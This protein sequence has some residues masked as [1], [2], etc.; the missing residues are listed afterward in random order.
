MRRAADNST[1]PKGGVSCSKD[2][3]MVNQT[4]IFQIKYCGKS[5][6]LRVAAKRY[7]QFSMTSKKAFIIFILLTTFLY[8]KGQE[9]EKPIFSIRHV[10]SWGP[11]YFDF[12]PVVAIYSSGKVL[13]KLANDSLVNNK[14]HYYT[15]YESSLSK[16]EIDSLTEQLPLREFYKLKDKYSPYEE[17][18]KIHISDAGLI[19][20]SVY[21]ENTSKSV[22]VYNTFAE[23]DQDFTYNPKAAK[24]IYDRLLSIR[25][26]IIATKNFKPWIPEK[27]EVFFIPYSKDFYNDRFQP[28]TLKPLKWPK[29]I[30]NL[31]SPNSYSVYDIS[32]FKLNDQK[33][34]KGITITKKE[35]IDFIIKNS[36]TEYRTVTVDGKKW[37][38]KYSFTGDN[39]KFVDFVMYKNCM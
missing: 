31:N 23:S 20:I 35:Q 6:A 15:I 18:R 37:I 11:D 5:P 14:L 26:K 38:I 12:F 17:Q 16:F 7:M 13:I 22:E 1:Y 30:P 27:L 8:S 2:S 21:S 32:G 29:D 4:L 34:Q 28:D 25:D 3:F 9:I 33:G 19:Y 24:I 10:T 36:Q 39:C